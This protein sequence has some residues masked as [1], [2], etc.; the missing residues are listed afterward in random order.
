MLCSHVCMLPAKPCIL[1]QV[2]HLYTAGSA[3]SRAHCHLLHV[4]LWHC[5]FNSYACSQLHAV[6]LQNHQHL[7]WHAWQNG[8][9]WQWWCLALRTQCVERGLRLSLYCWSLQ[10]VDVRVCSTTAFLSCGLQ[11]TAALAAY[12]LQIA[13]VAAFPAEP[14]GIFTTASCCSTTAVGNNTSISRM[15]ESL[16]RVKFAFCVCTD[17]AVWPTIIVRTVLLKTN[18]TVGSQVASAPEE[19]I[20]WKLG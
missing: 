13:C 17:M 5:V 20:C 16:L 1:H 3:A 9:W 18:P 10:G 19:T 14:G 12:V 11:S 15:T 6:A 8:C 4:T 7:K 2:Q